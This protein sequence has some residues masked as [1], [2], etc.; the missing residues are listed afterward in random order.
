M[1]NLAVSSRSGLSRLSSPIGIDNI[2][3]PSHCRKTT[4]SCSESAGTS[5]RKSIQLAMV[6]KRPGEL[7]AIQWGVVS[8]TDPPPW[9]CPGLKGS[10]HSVTGGASWWSTSCGCAECCFKHSF[11]HFYK[12]SNYIVYMLGRY[13]SSTRELIIASTWYCNQICLPLQ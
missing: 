7:K 3:L 5:F 1:A 11:Y 4:K 10:K 9:E 8:T 2:E 6:E 12:Y 13:E